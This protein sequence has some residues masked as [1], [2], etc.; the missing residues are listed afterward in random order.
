MPWPRTMPAELWGGAAA[1]R[2]PS[3]PWPA[4]AQVVPFLRWQQGETGKRF[5]S[6]RRKKRSEY[7]R[8][9]GR[10]A[11]QALFETGPSPLDAF[12]PQKEPVKPKKGKKGAQEEYTYHYP[13]PGQMNVSS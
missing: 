6:E 3:V 11:E 9:G 4:N 13:T 5:V 10:R 8:R 12:L 2:Q 1:T 7:E